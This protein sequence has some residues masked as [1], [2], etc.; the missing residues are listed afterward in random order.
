VDANT[1][2]DINELEQGI[3]ILKAL[4]TNGSVSTTKLI[5]N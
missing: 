5:K 1:S 2:M 4:D 3:Y